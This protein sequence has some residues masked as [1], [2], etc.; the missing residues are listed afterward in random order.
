[1]AVNSYNGSL[2]ADL[3]ILTTELIDYDSYETS[4]YYYT[5]FEP[6]LIVPRDSLTISGALL[7]TDNGDKILVEDGVYCENV[8]VNKEV[9]LRAIN[10]TG[11]SAGIEPTTPSLPTVSI[12]ANNVS[13]VGFKIANGSVGVK[14]SGQYCVAE[15]N[16]ITN[17]TIGV[18]LHNANNTVRSNYITGNNIGI[19]LESPPTATALIDVFVYN[20]ILSNGYYNETTGVG[21]ESV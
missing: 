12:N 21:V 14:V 18:L 1:M 7:Y 8:N 11:W 13:L 5:D 20:N 10:P 6:V 3:Y 2:N 4:Y 16:V 17:N 15:S 9:A 19:K